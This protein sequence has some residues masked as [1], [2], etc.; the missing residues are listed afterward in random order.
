MFSKTLNEPI[1][2]NTLVL[3]VDPDE[4]IDLLIQTKKPGSKVFLKPVW[5]DFSYQKGILMDAYEWVLQDCMHGD[6]LLFVREDGVEQAWSLLTPI[7]NKIEST[8]EVE[9]FPNY[10]AG[11]SGP[12]EAVQMIERDGRAW[13][14]L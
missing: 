6:P 4:G 1:A 2:P 14:P 10:A 8:T 12:E 5:L 3:R 7:I 9:K 13:R 11:S